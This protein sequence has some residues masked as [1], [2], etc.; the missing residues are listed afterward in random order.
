P[1]S[2]SNLWYFDH[3]TGTDRK[4]IALVFNAVDSAD[5]TPELLDQLY[6][7]RVPATFFLNGDFIGG[8]P[9]ETRMIAESGHTVGSLFYSMVDLSSA[10][11]D[12]N[13]LKKGLARNED[14]YFIATGREMAM[15]WHTP[16][17]FINSEILETS[18]SMQ[19][20]F[21]GTDIP[22][23]DRSGSPGGYD[24]VAEAEKLISRVRS[25]SI[26]TLT[27]GSG[28]GQNEY[29]FRALP[30]IFDHLIREG[31]TFVDLQDMMNASR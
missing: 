2:S 21:I 8:N 24:A 6:R 1:V 30:M 11:V 14:D 5:G 3:G 13:F 4:E 18:A 12:K 15:L 17:Y 20:V 23:N 25:G 29:L 28:E 22:V 31:Y 7:Y 10:Q 9:L 19:Y 16:G 27:I 26:L